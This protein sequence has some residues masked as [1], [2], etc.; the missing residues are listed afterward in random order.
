[1]LFAGFTG[2]AC[3]SP[4]RVWGQ[5]QK[6]Q[7]MGSVAGVILED[8]GHSYPDIRLDFYVFNGKPNDQ[9]TD[10][11]IHRWSASHGLAEG[12]VTTSDNG[13]YRF[14]LPA[15]L[16]IVVLKRQL[17]TRVLPQLEMEKA[18]IR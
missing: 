1:M 9:L 14:D 18:F 11:S 4:S 8:Q 16:H 2:F 12:G 3:A 6:Q 13:E 5:A 10:F 17:A 15:G 7:G